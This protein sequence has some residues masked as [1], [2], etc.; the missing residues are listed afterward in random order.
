V[1]WCFAF[2]PPLET[3]PG[4]NLLTTTPDVYASF[5]FAFGR[6]VGF[7][8]WAEGLPPFFFRADGLP[9]TF[10]PLFGLIADGRTGIFFPQL[11]FFFGLVVEVTF[12]PRK[13][14]S[15]P[16]FRMCRPVSPLPEVSCSTVRSTTFRRPLAV[17]FY[18]SVFCF[19]SG[20]P[21]CFFGRGFGS[22]PGDLPPPFGSPGTPWAIPLL[23]FGFLSLTSFGFLSP[24]PILVPFKVSLHPG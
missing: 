9:R 24:F 20:P 3:S 7:R 4:W 21:H 12:F 22:D 17:G 1:G 10:R 11:F 19:F 15:R 14:A 8:K 5:S 13:F 2:T 23:S 18:F 6:P 16:P